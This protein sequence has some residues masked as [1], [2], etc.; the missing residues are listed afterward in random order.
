MVREKYGVRLTAEQRNQ[1][2]HLVRAGK[3]HSPGDG[4]GPDSAQD[5]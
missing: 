3:R 2:Q 1:L 4:P 5:G